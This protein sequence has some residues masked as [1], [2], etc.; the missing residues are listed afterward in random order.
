MMAFGFGSK[1]LMGSSLTAVVSFDLLVY[2][3]WVSC[4]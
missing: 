2:R 4:F 3:W 1:L